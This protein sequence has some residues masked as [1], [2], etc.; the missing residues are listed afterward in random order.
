MLLR[1]LFHHETFTY[2]YLIADRESGVAALID[3]VLERVDN[4][5]TLLEEL[6]LELLMA[7]DTH[8]H[9]D[10]VTGSGR[11]REKTQCRTFV[12]NADQ[13]RCA[14]VSLRDGMHIQLGALV[15]EVLY[16][17]GHTND[18]YSFYVDDGNNKQVFT[19]DTLLIRGTGRTDFQNGD[20]GALYHSLHD[21]LLTLDPSTVV[22]PGHDYQGHT[23]STIKEERT[24]NPRVAIKDKHAF[25]S[26]MAQLGLAPPPHLETVVPANQQCGQI[27]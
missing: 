13:I 17:P 24:C 4:Y 11:L 14:D 23:C 22:Y 1:Q 21:I 12:G 3:P 8:V 2:T 25:E 19:G 5:L 16:T 26:H 20:A 10:H 9:A 27:R 7:I 15:I 6:D 18:S